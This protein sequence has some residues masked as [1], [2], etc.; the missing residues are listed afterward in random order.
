MNLAVPATN[1]IVMTQGI[2]PEQSLTTDAHGA[3][4]LNR[5]TP[6]PLTLLILVTGAKR[7]RLD[8]IAVVAGVQTLKVRVNSNDCRRLDNAPGA[9]VNPLGSPPSV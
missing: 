8:D 7:C 5:L 4:K 2:A 6:G 1:A 9:P 3:A